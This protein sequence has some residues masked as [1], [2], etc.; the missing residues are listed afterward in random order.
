[1]SL[2]TD[3]FFYNAIATSEDV[4]AIVGDRIFNPARDSAAEEED[5]IPYVIITFE[6]LTNDQST[7]DDD[8]EGSEDKVTIGILVVAADCD[9]LGDLAEAI[10]KRCREYREANQDDLLTPIG[11]QFSSSDVAYDPDKPCCFQTLTYQCDTNRD[12]DDED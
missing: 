1:M 9:K 3:K 2:I 11:W 10:R 8:T 4:T 5:R 7:K 12:T 6:G